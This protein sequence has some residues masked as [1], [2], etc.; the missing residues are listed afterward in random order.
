MA[1]NPLKAQEL[2]ALI[3]RNIWLRR[4]SSIFENA[5]NDS[6]QVVASTKRQLEA[7]QT[8]SLQPERNAQQ[9]ATK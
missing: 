4:N 8:A 7:F 3:C 2:C 9:Q 1:E 5:F 6:K